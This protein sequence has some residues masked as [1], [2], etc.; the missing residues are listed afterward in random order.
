MPFAFTD[1]EMIF[2]EDRHA[3]DWIF[4]YGNEKL[5]EVERVPLS[6]LI[7]NSFGNIFSNMEINGCVPMNGQR[8]MENGLRLWRIVRR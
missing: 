7:G 6:G 1:I 5:A 4:R 8:C 3:V 2:N